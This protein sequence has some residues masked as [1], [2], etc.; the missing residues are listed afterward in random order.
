MR[1]KMYTSLPMVFYVRCV[2]LCDAI[3]AIPYVHDSYSELYKEREREQDSSDG[4]GFCQL[5]P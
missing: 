2:R 4:S 1:Y 5:E 3:T